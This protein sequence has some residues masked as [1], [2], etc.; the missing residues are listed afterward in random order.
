MECLRRAG[1]SEALWG[2]VDRWHVGSMIEPMQRQ[3]D[4][5]NR[6]LQAL[7]N[8]TLFA[9]LSAEAYANE[10]LASQFEGRELEVLD[11]LNVVDKLTLAPAFAGYESPV[12]RGRDPIQT[13]EKLRRV[14]NRLVHSKPGAGAYAHEVD[15]AEANQDYGPRAVVGYI[16]QV[17]HAAVLLHPYRDDR[18]FTM[19][20]SRVWDERAI[21]T[22]HVAATGEDLFAIPPEDSPVV[23]NLFIQMQ[24]AA[25]ERAEPEMRRRAEERTAAL[26]R[27]RADRDA[28]ARPATDGLE[29]GEKPTS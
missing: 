10:F 18:S 23:R 20:F 16:E 5:K 25:Y 19:P 2:E 12:A 6:R 14:R 24:D 4:A 21:L 22:D 11:G 13:I 7:R 27:R 17:A 28:R 3:L 15:A 1:S 9:A 29:P 8:A 26:E